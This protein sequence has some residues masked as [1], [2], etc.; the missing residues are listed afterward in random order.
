MTP[1]A[2]AK[3]AD[4]GIDINATDTPEK[5]FFNVVLKQEEGFINY[6]F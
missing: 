2:M 6:S 4:I 5:I 1:D 3:A